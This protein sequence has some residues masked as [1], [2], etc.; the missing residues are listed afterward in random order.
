M[1]KKKT[2]IRIDKI[3]ILHILDEIS[4][5]K[6]LEQYKDSTDP[7]E[8]KYEAQ[9]AERRESYGLSWHYIGIVAHAEVSYQYGPGSRRI[10]RFESGGLWGIETDSEDSYLVEVATEQFSDLR[11]HLEVFGVDT[12]NFDEVASTAKTVFRA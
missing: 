12:S 6:D 8:Q 3:T 7:E 4:D 1:A 9:D 2:Q 10:E 5:T 11:R